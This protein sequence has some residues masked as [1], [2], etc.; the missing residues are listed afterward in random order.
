[1]M[2]EAVRLDTHLAIGSDHAPPELLL[3]SEEGGR[4]GGGRG[5]EGGP[6][7]AA[8]SLPAVIDSGAAMSGAVV[9]GTAVSGAAVSGATVSGTAVSGAAMS[10]ATVSGA[11]MSGAVVSGDDMFGDDVSGA[12]VSSD[13][14]A[15]IGDVIGGR[16]TADGL[17]VGVAFAVGVASGVGVGGGVTG[18]AA[19][20]GVMSDG[21]GVSG[22]G[23]TGADEMM[24]AIGEVGMRVEMLELPQAELSED[25]FDDSASSPS[26]DNVVPNQARP[27]D[28]TYNA[29]PDNQAC[30][31]NV[32]G[33]NVPV[34]GIDSTFSRSI[35]ADLGGQETAS[36]DSNLELQSLPVLES[37]A[38][39]NTTQAVVST[40]ATSLE[41]EEEGEDEA[42]TSLPRDQV[43]SW[44]DVG[45]HDGGAAVRAEASGDPPASMASADTVSQL[46]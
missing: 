2:R 15:N 17:S 10:G 32:G 12:A 3:G 1:M 39:I 4:E 13:T 33:A 6:R 37:G 27:S 20:D 35:A 26:S 40:S 8:L 25:I 5:G 43:A 45:E 23:V 31:G 44:G 18:D 42:A 11:T 36:T 38:T 46:G 24:E 34:E 9:S 30:P 28:V 21:A 29:A 14:V 22:E 16:E 19:S 41:W 7:S